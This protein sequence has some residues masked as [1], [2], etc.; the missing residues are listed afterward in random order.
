MSSPFVPIVGFG[1]V[2]L[3]CVSAVPFRAPSTAAAPTV[4]P[5]AVTD[6]RFLPP[7][8][9]RAVV[10][11]A[12]AEFGVPLDIAGR[13]AYEE[14]RWNPEAV[15]QNTNGTTDRGLYQLNS[16]YHDPKSVR[17]NVRTGLRY[18]AQCWRTTG[19]WKRAV[20]AY[21]AGPSRVDN[22]PERSVKLARRVTGGGM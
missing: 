10:I 20:V 9:F 3:T 1:V 2:L 12:A 19:S 16:A 17:E 4:L 13:L 7:A 8:E 18:L 21:N 15:G 5:V 22:P 14:S 6:S 11:S